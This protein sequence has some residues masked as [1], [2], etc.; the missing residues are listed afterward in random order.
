MIGTHAS[1]TRAQAGRRTGAHRDWIMLVTI[2]SR[3]GCGA[4]T[5]AQRLAQRLGYELIDEQ[6]PVVVAKRLGTNAE[7]V[8]SAEDLGRSVGE[9]VLRGLELG[10]PELRVQS[11]TFDEECLRE[12]QQA[13][14][15]F[16]PRGKV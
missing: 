14:R 4:L 7:A 3:Y 10:T 2:S 9:R 11:P 1:F 16:A 13:G 15:D 6:L 5:V 8:E 12:V